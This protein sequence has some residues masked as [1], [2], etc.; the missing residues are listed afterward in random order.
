[1]G[2]EVDSSE[3]PGPSRKELGDEW[4]DEREGWPTEK[5]KEQGMKSSLATISVAIRILIR[6]L[7]LLCT[8]LQSR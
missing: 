8:M 5:T 3:F 6:F 1:L 2:I 7:L 4:E